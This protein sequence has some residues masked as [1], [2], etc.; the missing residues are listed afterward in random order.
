M[1]ETEE[2]A[3]KFAAFARF[4]I[5]SL[6]EEKKFPPKAECDV[7]VRSEDVDSILQ[8]LPEAALAVGHDEAKHEAEQLATDGDLVI[9][10]AT[11]VHE[12]DRADVVLTFRRLAA[13]SR[14]KDYQGKPG[15]VIVYMDERGLEVNPFIT[16]KQ[17]VRFPFAE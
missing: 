8:L 14:S 7:I 6:I 12:Q 9:L 15:E 5:R 16:V 2:R 10:R 3:Q 17:P 13:D 4:Q 1:Y 11:H